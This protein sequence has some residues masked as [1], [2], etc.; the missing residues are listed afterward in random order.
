MVRVLEDVIE[1]SSTPAAERRRAEAYLA[2]LTGTDIDL[3][4][5]GE[6][7]LKSGEDDEYLLGCAGD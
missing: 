1:H 5:G 2:E 7:Q 6:A 4:W 3:V